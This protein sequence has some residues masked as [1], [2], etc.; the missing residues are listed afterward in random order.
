[1]DN[2]LI[3]REPLPV[4]GKTRLTIEEYLEFER[5][6]NQKHEYYQGEVFTMSGA[7]DEHALISRNVLVELGYHSKGNKCRPVGDNARLYIPENTLFTYPDISIYCNDV[8]QMFGDQNDNFTRPSAL[9][10]ILSK[11]TEKYDRGIKFELYKTIPSL[12][13]YILIDSESIC[14]DSF[15]KKSKNIWISERLKD[16]SDKL[17]IQTLNVSVTL[18]E[19][20]SETGLDGGP[21]TVLSR[22][23]IKF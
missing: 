21:K 3:I 10:E 17:Y 7:S 20:Y 14:I 8:K 12:Q 4:Y 5:E 23:N 13:E 2:D 6:S 11:S 18:S 19:I 1:M 9:I 15:R 22:P 16:L